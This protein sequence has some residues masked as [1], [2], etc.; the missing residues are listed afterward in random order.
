[1][2]GFEVA[3]GSSC[4]PARNMM[5]WT[6]IEYRVESNVEYFTPGFA[7]PKRQRGGGN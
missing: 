7:N 1:M 2:S 5:K 3:W 6:Q 4:E